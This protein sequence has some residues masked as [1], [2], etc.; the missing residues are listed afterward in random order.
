MGL[1]LWCLFGDGLLSVDD[2]AGHTL[3]NAL[4]DGSSVMTAGRGEQSAENRANVTLLL[5]AQRINE[6]QFVLTFE[7]PETTLLIGCKKGERLPMFAVELTW[8]TR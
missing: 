2:S 5:I 6:H 4:A 3:V 1:F 7:K 8:I